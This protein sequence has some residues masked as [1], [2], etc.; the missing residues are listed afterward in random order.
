MRVRDQGNRPDPAAAE[1]PLHEYT[2]HPYPG[3]QFWVTL[4]TPHTDPEDPGDWE[5]LGVF[6]TK[7]EAVAFI[8]AHIPTN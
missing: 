1:A 4:T 5:D 8:A 2:I 3:G 6:P 7:E